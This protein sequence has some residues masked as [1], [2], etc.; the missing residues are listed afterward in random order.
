MTMVFLTICCVSH[1]FVNVAVHVEE[2]EEAGYD[3]Y[4]F[5]S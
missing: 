4:I 5:N 3:D 1:R 2:E